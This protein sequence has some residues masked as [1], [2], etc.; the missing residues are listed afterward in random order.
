MRT[1][2][3]LTVT[4]VG[5]GLLTALTVAP[6]AAIFPQLHSMLAGPAIGGR[7]PQGEAKLDQSRYP[8]EPSRLEV[9]VRNVNLPDGTVLPV[10]VEGTLVGSVTLSRGEGRL[11]TTVTFQVGR[12]SPI[13]VS[14]D[15]VVILRGTWLS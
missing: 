7:I 5:I 9:R 15:G 12:Q 2:T 4:L 3:R 10:A 14:H 13:T 6:A 11:A 8:V 1:I